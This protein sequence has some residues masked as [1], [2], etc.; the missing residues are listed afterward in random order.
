[1]S[2]PGSSDPGVSSYEDPP[3]DVSSQF[4]TR[5]GMFRIKG[6]S[7]AGCFIWLTRWLTLKGETLWIQKSVVSRYILP[8]IPLSH[9]SAHVTL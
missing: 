3:H 9:A 6:Y 7:F 8:K 2:R 5:T 1:M 4:Y